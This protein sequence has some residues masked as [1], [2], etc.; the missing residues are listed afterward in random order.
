MSKNY[1]PKDAENEIIT[2][3]DE[4]KRLRK[5]IN[6]AGIADALNT[7]QD[8]QRE[9]VQWKDCRERLLSKCEENDYTIDALE[10]TIS[11]MCDR[12]DC[13]KTTS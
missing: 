13:N 2:L 7:I 6:D 10:Q 9:L 1:K 8:L 5:Q 3:R 12:C 11:T 4:N